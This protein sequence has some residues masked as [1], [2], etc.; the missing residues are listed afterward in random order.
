MQIV[1]FNFLL[2]AL[3]VANGLSAQ[4]ALPEL[5]YAY[6][7]LEPHIDAMT[8]EIHHSKHHKAYLDNLNKATSLADAGKQRSIEDMLISVESN[9]SVQ[10][11]G[12]GHYNHTLFWNV[13]SPTPKTAPE[14]ELANEINKSFTSLDNLKKT[15]NDEGLK[16]FGSGWVWLFINTSGQLEV[17][18]LPN[19]DNPL[20]DV[21]G[22][23][24]GIPILG[25]DVWEHAY[26]LKY[27]N[28]RGDFLSAVWNVID[29]TA[30]EKN[31]T[32]AKANKL[33]MKKIELDGWAAFREFKKTYTPVIF[34][35]Q[36]GKYDELKYRINEV[37][38]KAEALSKSNIPA[39][40]QNSTVRA[41]L[42]AIKKESAKLQEL[43]EKKKK[44]EQLKKT[45]DELQ[46]EYEEL[47]KFLAV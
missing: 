44:E 18:S 39:S 8:M 21:A 35:T 13:L 17:A 34:P 9:K 38:M 7:A 46:R 5:K 40:L 28:K 23:K 33:L 27:Q 36:A 16:R 41:R 31:Y 24:R 29:W 20:M 12:G 25:I 4:F 1:K 11:N 45:F 32:D 15:M 14:G 42:S 6:D 30:V 2:G 19:Q 26:Y 22:T 37:A 10:N 3:F 43:I 47:L